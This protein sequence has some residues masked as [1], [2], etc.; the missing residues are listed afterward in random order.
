M[1]HLDKWYLEVITEQGAVAIVYVARL[2]WGRIRVRYAST[3]LST[4]SE[5]PR[6]TATV[7]GVR[8]P[9]LADGI[10]TWEH[11]ALR[12]SG[13]W[14]RDEPPIQRTLASGP[15][16]VIQWTCHMPRARAI[17][18]C[19]DVA[20]AGHGYVES[21]RLTIPPSELPFRT[22]RWGH[23]A[24]DRHSVVWIDW[25]GR[26]ARRWVWLDGRE[27]P[28]VM[29]TDS[30]LSGLGGGDAL[31]LSDSR[32]VLDR[33]V[34]AALGRVVPVLGRHLVGPLADMHEHKILSRSAIVRAGQ[35]ADH[36][37]TLHEVVTW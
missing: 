9:R 33:R 29:V 17:V 8:T 2:D 20:F 23:H 26:D 35:A 27:Q 24:S 3:L 30:G 10:L 15:S 28:D 1:F 31:Q 25:I 5:P 36:G 16:G 18:Q 4:V 14:S 34:L 7:R 37:W 11:A 21:L 19:G 32:D 6:E 12:V 13:R 22:L